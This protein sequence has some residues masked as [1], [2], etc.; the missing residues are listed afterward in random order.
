MMLE[1]AEWAALLLSLRVSFVA[2]L[3]SLPLAVYVAWLLARGQ[4]R[5]HALLSAFVLWC[6]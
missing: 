4:F 1:P 2:V 5:G 3:V 6:F